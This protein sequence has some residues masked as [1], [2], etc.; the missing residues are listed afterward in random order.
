MNANTL[1]ALDIAHMALL[2]IRQAQEEGRDVSA[3]ELAA[4]Q[5]KLAT[6]IARIQGKIDQMP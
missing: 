6:D 4:V 5:D 2:A 3:A 1:A